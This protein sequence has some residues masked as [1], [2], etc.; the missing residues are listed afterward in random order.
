M[1]S[2]LLIMRQHSEARNR[3]W[4]RAN[5]VCKTD[6]VRFVGGSAGGI[7]SS[8]VVVVLGRARD[9]LVVVTCVQP[10]ESV[11][12]RRFLALLLFLELGRFVWGM[13]HGVF[14]GIQ[15]FFFFLCGLYI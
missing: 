6:R 1:E 14:E 7:R 9:R 2:T 3:S 10:V 11:T 12:W 4:W 8:V 5:C 13:V 15:R